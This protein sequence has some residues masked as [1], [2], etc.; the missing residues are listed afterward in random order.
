MISWEEMAQKRELPIMDSTMPSCAV[1][2]S[3]VACSQNL[4]ESKS[5]R[6]HDFPMS[7]ERLMV[8]IVHLFG[9]KLSLL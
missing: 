7:S 2:F 8:L 6:G 3:F 5:V 9:K 4:S 1:C